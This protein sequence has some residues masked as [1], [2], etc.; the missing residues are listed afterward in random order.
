M[1]KD[2]VEEPKQKLQ[3]RMEWM[4]E[5][6]ENGYAIVK[7]EKPE[8]LQVH[9]HNVYTDRAPTPLEV[10]CWLVFGICFLYVLTFLV[11]I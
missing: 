1:S 5:M 2:T 6:I 7:I 9:K 11:A 4:D 3:T 10:L 8:L